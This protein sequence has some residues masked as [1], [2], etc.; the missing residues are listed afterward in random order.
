[1]NRRTRKKN[2]ARS[3]I[4]HV[5][6]NLTYHAL[7]RYIVGAVRDSH[8]AVPQLLLR[9]DVAVVLQV[10]LVERRVCRS[11]DSTSG[12]TRLLKRQKTAQIDEGSVPAVSNV[13]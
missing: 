1:M 4:R 7:R 12:V 8:N 6:D 3:V 10:A 2:R 9:R 13:L 5:P 11:V